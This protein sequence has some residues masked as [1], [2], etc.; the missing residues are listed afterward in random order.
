VY[1][2]VSRVIEFLLW[3]VTKMHFLLDFHTKTKCP[4]LSQSL[5][6]INVA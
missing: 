1:I 3:G 4:Y 6:S 5:G 2:S